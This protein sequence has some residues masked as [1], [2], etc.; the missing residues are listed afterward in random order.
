MSE[1]VVTGGLKNFTYNKNVELRLDDERK[2]DIKEAYN[3][4]Y[5]ACQRYSTYKEHNNQTTCS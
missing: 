2:N 4:Y 3:K 1:Q 5:E